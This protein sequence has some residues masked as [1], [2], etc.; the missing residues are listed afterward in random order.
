[1]TGL[2]QLSLSSPQPRGDG[3]ALPDLEEPSGAASTP[4]QPPDR[5]EADS[6]SGVI[7]M[8]AAKLRVVRGSGSQWILQI[9]GPRIWRNIAF[10]GTRAGLIQS[11]KDHL[12]KEHLEKLGLYQEPPKHLLRKACDAAV[13]AR[14]LLARGE[15]AAFEADARAMAII[16]ALPAHF[17]PEPASPEAPG[18]TEG[19]GAGGK[20]PDALPARLEAPQKTRCPRR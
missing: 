3:P 1:M 10:C 2:Q 20:M 13:G 5:E 14:D 19:T 15:F 12:L 6:Y 9:R 18:A 17:R 16:E 8:L 4:E 7:A 11:I